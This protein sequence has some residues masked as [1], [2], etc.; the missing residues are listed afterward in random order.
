MGMSFI[1]IFTNLER[2]L[3]DEGVQSPANGALNTKKK[4]D[5]KG[6]FKELQ[7]QAELLEWQEATEM[8]EDK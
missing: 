2:I 8:I 6:Y 3:Y 5:P 1:E 7:K 4:N